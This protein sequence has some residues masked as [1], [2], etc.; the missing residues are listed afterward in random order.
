MLDLLNINNTFFTIWDYPMSY[1]EF[2]GTI[3]NIAA[4]WLVAKKKISNWPVGILAVLLF[5]ALFW[6]LQLYSDFIEQ[7]YYL[8]TGVWGWW[9]WSQYKKKGAAHKDLPV[10]MV[11]TKGKLVTV[12]S[13]AVGSAALGYFIS[14]IHTYWPGLFP[15]PASYAYLDAT[16]TVMSFAAQILLALRYLENWYIWIAVDV[17]GIWLYFVKGVKLVSVLY[18][19]FLVLAVRGALKWRRDHKATVS[20]SVMGE[21]VTS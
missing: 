18:A 19:I 3:L 1:I 7:I 5:G 17:I 4:V 12:A 2:F 14:N 21:G 16:T 13:I 6:Q 9:L 15:A 20:E 8:V 10:R 11:S